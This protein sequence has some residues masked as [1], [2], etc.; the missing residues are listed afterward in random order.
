MGVQVHGRGRDTGHHGTH[1]PVL[2]RRAKF[3]IFNLSL[4][5]NDRMKQLPILPG[6]GPADRSYAIPVEVFYT[7]NDR[8]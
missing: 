7:S 2:V 8:I 5:L 6:G 1:S 3:P 4:T